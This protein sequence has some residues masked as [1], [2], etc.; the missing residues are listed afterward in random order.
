MY[1]F[2]EIG[3]RVAVIGEYFLGNDARYMTLNGSVTMTIE[4]KPVTLG[5][6][7]A[8]FIAAGTL[9]GNIQS[10]GSEPLV[11][12]AMIGA[13]FVPQWGKPPVYGMHFFGNNSEMPMA[14][15]FFTFPRTCNITALVTL[16]T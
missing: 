7:D 14:T 3:G 9:H 12:L 1:N 2:A 8:V 16:V 10:A 13:D 11:S 4:G 15:Q 5:Y 6:L